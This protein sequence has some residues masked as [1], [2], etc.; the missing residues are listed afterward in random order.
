[1]GILSWIVL[2]LIAGAL[3]K[4]IMPGDQRGGCVLTTLL[5]VAGALVGGFIGQSLGYGGVQTFSLG[6]LLWAILGSLLLLLVF[7]FLFKKRRP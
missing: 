4:L 2:G 7:G 6:S 1:M 3:A 5:G